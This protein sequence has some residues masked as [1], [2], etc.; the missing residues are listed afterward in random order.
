MV[1]DDPPA[2]QEEAKDDSRYEMFMNLVKKM[3][4]TFP[5]P[6]DMPLYSDFLAEV[7]ARKW[8]KDDHELVASREEY[9]S[10][11]TN[12]VPVKLD[13]LGSFSIPCT[14][15]NQKVDRVLCDLGGSVSVIPLMN[16]KKLYVTNLTHTSIKIKLADGAIKPP[17]GILKDIMV[18]VNKLSIPV[19][20]VAMDIPMGRRSHIILG[21]SFLATGGAIVDVQR[22]SLSFEVGNEKV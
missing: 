10:V 18:K 22:R 20:F 17:I 4:A 7:V 5:S 8:S 15:G 21:R 13:N 9:N 1:E 6:E 3:E 19:D 12:E 16:V 2:E 11:I 14:I